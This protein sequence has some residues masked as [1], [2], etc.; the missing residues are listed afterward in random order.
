M[1]AEQWTEL[2]GSLVVSYWQKWPIACEVKDG[3]EEGKRMGN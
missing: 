2:I 1:M 3:K